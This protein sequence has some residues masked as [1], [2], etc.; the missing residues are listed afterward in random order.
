[1]DTCAG[2]KVRLLAVPVILAALA[3]GN[4]ERPAPEDLPGDGTTDEGTDVAPDARGDLP[5]ADASGDPGTLPGSPLAI[6]V[7][8]SPPSLVLR[9]ADGEIVAESLPGDRVVTDAAPLRR[10]PVF[11]RSGGV[12]ALLPDTVRRAEPV[13]GR[14]EVPDASTLGRAR[15]EVLVGGGDRGSLVLADGT[16]DT[17]PTRVDVLPVDGAP[18]GADWRACGPGEDPWDSDCLARE[19][20]WTLVPRTGP[21]EVRA[22]G[23][24]VSIAGGPATR[25]YLVRIAE[26]PSL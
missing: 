26:A 23:M 25:R 24:V 6:E 21:G 12:A 22:A 10:I 16:G 1:M 20:H 14:P 15:L 8:T 9:A 5:G 11:L 4:S 18:T 7:R 19:G 2:R 3:C 17:V 13:P